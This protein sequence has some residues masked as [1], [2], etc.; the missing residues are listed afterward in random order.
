MNPYNRN[1]TDYTTQS[2]PPRAQSTFFNANMSQQD[3]QEKIAF[4]RREADGL[5]EKI[6][7]AKAQTADIERESVPHASTR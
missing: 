2:T 5:K 3:I 6:K 1:S 7:I 4:A